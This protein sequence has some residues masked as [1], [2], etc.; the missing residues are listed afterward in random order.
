MELPRFPVVVVTGLIQGKLHDEVT[1]ELS[2]LSVSK[3]K[4]TTLG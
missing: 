4:A 1:M 2:K 3:P